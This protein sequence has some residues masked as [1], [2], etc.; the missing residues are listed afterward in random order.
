MVTIMA[1]II[2][3]GIKCHWNFKLLEKGYMAITLF[4]HIFFRDSKEFVEKYLNTR[5]GEITVNHERIHMLQADT[6]KTKYF[7]FYV[8][9]LWYWITGLFKYGITKYAS[10]M[11]IPFEKEARANQEDMNYSKS[12]WRKYI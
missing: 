6:F 7:G 3:N 4:G 9:Y 2:K 5:R 1:Y 11:Q 12:N 8:Y 10:Y